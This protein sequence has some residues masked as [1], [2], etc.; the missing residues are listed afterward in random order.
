MSQWSAKDYKASAKS[1]TFPSHTINV[2]MCVNVS[3]FVCLLITVIE[4]KEVG[5]PRRCGGQGDLL[6]DK[7]RKSKCFSHSW[8]HWDS[9]SYISIS[10]C[11]YIASFHRSW[12]LPLGAA[13]WW[14]NVLKLHLES[15]KEPCWL[16]IWYK[17]LALCSSQNL[18][19]LHKIATLFQGWINFMITTA[20][21]EPHLWE[22]KISLSCSNHNPW[23]QQVEIFK[24]SWS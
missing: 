21:H 12:W 7:L 18:N 19:R 10:V 15:I 4:C 13:I 8:H 14:R 22:F 17:K 20:Y 16:V 5:C 6:S 1:A 24:A 9:H 3:L 2:Y 11:L 23:S